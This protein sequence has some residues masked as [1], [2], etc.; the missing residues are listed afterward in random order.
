M[1]LED[2]MDTPI[3]LLSGGQRQALTLLMATLREPPILLLDEH[4]AALDPAS[5]EHILELTSRIIAQ[6]RLTTIMVTHD[7][8]EAV[9]FGSRLLMM[10]RG[11]VV[12]DVAGVEKETLTEQ[13]LL[14][15]FASLGRQ[16]VM[17][18]S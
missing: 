2:R 9:R 17:T 10:D 15:S 16:R 11:K 5:A 18:K 8:A 7:M 6:K 1:G 14:Q 3:G 13:N 12:R 4:T